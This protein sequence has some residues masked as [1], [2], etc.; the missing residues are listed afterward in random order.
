MGTD[1]QIASYNVNG[2]AN[3]SKRIQIFMWLKEKK[4]TIICL[5]ETHS[6]PAEEDLSREEWGG[7]IWFSHGLK[8]TR[9][10]II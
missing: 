6:V 4:Y 2:L 3:K 7:S 5:Q 10:V 1:I 9:G 8:N